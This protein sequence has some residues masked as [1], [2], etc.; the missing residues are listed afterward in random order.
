MNDFSQQSSDEN[1]VERFCVWDWVEDPNVVHART[2]MAEI[3]QEYKI[4]TKAD[5]IDA[6]VDE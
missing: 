4:D 3:L 5:E 1:P 6:S 2:A